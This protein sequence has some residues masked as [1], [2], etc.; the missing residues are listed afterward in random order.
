MV[1][2]GT[3]RALE[4]EVLPKQQASCFGLR[5][6]A[7]AGELKAARH[8]AILRCVDHRGKKLTVVASAAH[9]E[10]LLGGVPISAR[11]EL[12]LNEELFP[13]IVN[14]WLNSDG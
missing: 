12:D 9:A 2:P 11:N 3:V 10:E 1:R 8:L 5:N 14:G 4:W 6:T 13:V 7:L